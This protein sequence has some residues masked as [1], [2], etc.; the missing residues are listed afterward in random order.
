M[1]KTI[2]EEGLQVTIQDTIKCYKDNFTKYWEGEKYKWIAVKHYREHWNI[3]T[4][5][6][7]G[8]LIEAFSQSSNLLSGAMYYPYRMLCAFAQFD[9]EKMRELFRV[10]YTEELPLYDRIQSFRAGCED[11]LTAFRE[12]SPEYAKAKN[13]YQDLRAICEYLSFE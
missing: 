7:A 8:M 4:D 13:H 10:F 9:S 3:D 5:D 6:F 2:Q 12:S 1:H 11:L